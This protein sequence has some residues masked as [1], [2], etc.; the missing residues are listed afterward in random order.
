GPA[1]FN[2]PDDFQFHRLW[3]LMA[4]ILRNGRTAKSPISTLVLEGIFSVAGDRLN[5]VYGKQFHKIVPQM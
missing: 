2:I 3:T 5:E 1:A 4:R